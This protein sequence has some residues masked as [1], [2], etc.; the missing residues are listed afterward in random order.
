MFSATNAAFKSGDFI[1]TIE[2][3]TSS[4]VNLE[5]SFLIFSISSP[6]RPITTPGLEVLIITFVLFLFLSITIFETEEPFNL[7]SKY[8]LILMSVFNT[9]EKSLFGAYHL[10][11][12]SLLIPLLNPTGLT[13]CPLKES[14]FHPF[15]LHR[16]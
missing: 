14:P 4:P 9:I 16:Y 8:S 10:L 15:L 7:F 12:Q 11:S 2:I 6:P 3:Y 1:S 5:S 13:F